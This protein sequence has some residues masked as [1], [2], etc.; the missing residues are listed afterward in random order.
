M[1]SRSVGSRCWTA[2]DASRSCPS[3]GGRSWRTRTASSSSAEMPTSWRSGSK[4]NCRSPP[5]KT[6][7][8]HQ[9]CRY[10]DSLDTLRRT[11]PSPSVPTVHDVVPPLTQGKLQKHQAFEAEVQANS[12]AIVKLDDTGNLMI[13]EGHFASETIRVRYSSSPLC[14]SHRLE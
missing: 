10:V 14:L 5:T 13:S 2:T 1:T 11:L 3:C 8:T 12:A 7:K 4:R 6:T 9:T